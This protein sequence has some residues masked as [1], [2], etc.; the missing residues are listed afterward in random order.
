M[1]PKDF[2][3]WLFLNIREQRFKITTCFDASDYNE[4]K[5]GKL[6]AAE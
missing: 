5:N 1:E 3:G 6:E 2:I 4:A